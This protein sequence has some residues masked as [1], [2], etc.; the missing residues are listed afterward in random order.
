MTGNGRIDYKDLNG[1]LGNGCG[2][3]LMMYVFLA[4]CI[5]MC[6]WGILSCGQCTRREVRSDTVMVTRTDTLWLTD[7]MPVV[8]AE[9]IVRYVNVPVSPVQSDTAQ[10]KADSVALPV[11]QREYADTC[12]TAWVSGVAVDSAYPR[13]DSIRVRERVVTRETTITN[14][15]TVRKK[16]SR[17][18]VGVQAGYGYG[19][20]YGGMEPY[21]GVGVTWSPFR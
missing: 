20:G 5:A 14:T 3:T 21:V 17:W 8:R 13:L 11:V 18:K 10:G 4:A 7:T 16:A 19:L 9:R 12:Y 6:C 2:P 1:G 15:I